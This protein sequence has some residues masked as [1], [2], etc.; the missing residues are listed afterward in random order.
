MYL[1]LEGLF[2]TLFV[3]T[4]QANNTVADAHIVYKLRVWMHGTLYTK[5][6][7][8]GGGG[9]KHYIYSRESFPQACPC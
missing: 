3:P 2:L 7:G 6:I 9:S 8:G 1:I 5:G 4:T